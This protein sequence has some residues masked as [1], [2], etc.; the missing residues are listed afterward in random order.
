M[1]AG[2]QIAW[3]RTELGEFRRSRHPRSTA[4]GDKKI[5]DQDRRSSD[6]S[7]RLLV[8]ELAANHNRDVEP[9]PVNQF[10]TNLCLTS[11]PPVQ[12][13]RKSLWL[14]LLYQAPLWT[15]PS[16]PTG[17]PIARLAE[18]RRSRRW[19][20]PTSLR[21]IRYCGVLGRSIPI[22]EVRSIA[23]CVTRCAHAW[24]SRRPGSKREATAPCAMIRV[25]RPSLCAVHTFPRNR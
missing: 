24:T 5:G 15:G 25:I 17:R 2:Y 6:S 23:I 9:S 3:N 7:A 18:K 12:L 8:D 16:R 10:R 14:R 20:R 13:F 21:L 19:R 4:K 1:W 22:G 11:I